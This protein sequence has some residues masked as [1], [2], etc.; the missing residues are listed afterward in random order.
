[1]R[2]NSLAPVASP[3]AALALPPAALAAIELWHPVIRT[4]TAAGLQPLVTHA[5]TWLV[6]HLLQLVLFGLTGWA[7]ARLLADVRSVPASV[8]RAALAVFA[9]AYSA[10]DTF[11]GLATVTVIKAGQGMPGAAQAVSV[12][13]ANA[14]FTSPVNAALFLVGTASWFLGTALT[15]IVLLR[16]GAP[17]I[18]AVLLLLAAAALWGDHPPPFGPVTFGL[19]S[20]AILWFAL[21]GSVRSSACNRAA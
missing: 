14:I 16:A 21:R 13:L 6:I 19:T 4:G 17:R 12:E 1:M 11:A 5:D 8:A 9:V 2:P 15:A 10:F 7:V 18:P 20:L 3:P